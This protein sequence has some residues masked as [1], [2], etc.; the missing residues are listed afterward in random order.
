VE[1]REEAI[2]EETKAR[3]LTGEDPRNVLK[4]EDALRKA[5]KKRGTQGLLEKGS[6][7]FSIG[8]EPAR[9]VYHS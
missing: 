8:T 5:L 3:L 1:R 9:S 2:E 7:T 4:K 6:G